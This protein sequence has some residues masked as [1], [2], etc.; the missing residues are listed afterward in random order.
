MKRVCLTAMAA[1]VL[2][3]GA[4]FAHDQ[5]KDQRKA[6]TSV[7]VGGGK[8]ITISYL[9]RHWSESAWNNIVSNAQAR[10]NFNRFL[11]AFASL[12]TPVA[13][14]VGDATVPAG[15]YAQAGFQVGDK[16]EWY[17][18]IRGS[19]G[20]DLSKV[21]L[22]ATDAKDISSHLTLTLLPGSAAGSFDL[23]YRYGSRMATVTFTSTES[24]HAT[25]SMADK[26]EDED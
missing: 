15:E 21:A 12:S 26:D 7:D 20:K 24:G 9:P 8:S 18:I 3:A 25:K 14:K 22:P 10:G 13:L 11:P 6:G 16:G 5:E 1:S 4:A 2:F 19:D 23:V 17:W